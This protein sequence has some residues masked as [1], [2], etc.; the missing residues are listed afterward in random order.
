MKQGVAWCG[1]LA[2]ALVVCEA[3]GQS[4]ETAQAP[5]GAAASD[6]PIVLDLVVHDRKGK[7]V[8]D[9]KPEDL[10]ITDD[11]D[12]IKLENLRLANNQKQSESLITLV[13]DRPGT[14]DGLE[15]E[16]SSAAMKDERDAAAKILKMALPHGFTFSVFSVQRRLRLEHEFTSDKNVLAEAVN[17]ATEPDKP[18]R[19]SAASATE[20]NLISVALTGAD[21]AGKRATAHERVLAQALY[22][23]LTSAG[24]IARDQHTRPS[25]A[26]LLALTQ[27]EQQI[28]QRKAI[29]YFS[30]I[31]DKQIDLHARAAI[32][33]IVG[34]ANR[35]GVSI[36]VVD[37]NSTSGAGASAVST[38]LVVSDGSG[39][40]SQPEGYNLSQLNTD[41][42]QVRSD[43][44]D[45]QQLAEHTGGSYISGDRLPKQVEQ[46]IGDMSTYY[47]AS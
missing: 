21:A 1:L 27:A 26:G 43:A 40:A 47:E 20:K 25:L 46:L 4:A 11:G 7:S 36:Y 28:A 13:F 35:A 30:S 45:M 19:E 8:V 6:D 2:V 5:P 31:Q 23:A 29:L 9:L 24:P 38:G 33:S 18:G 15:Q 3:I 10:A 32:H 41:A 42:S 22:R 17:A 12:P 14:E 16:S 44:A 37:V 34:T 39:Y